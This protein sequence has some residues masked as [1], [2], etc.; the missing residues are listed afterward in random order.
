MLPITTAPAADHLTP[1]KF[2]MLVRNFMATHL[3]IKP[4]PLKLFLLELP[5]RH[6]VNPEMEPLA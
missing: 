3:P 6:G 1:Q 2:T 5:S 4:D